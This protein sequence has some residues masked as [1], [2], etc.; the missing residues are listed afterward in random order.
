[1]ASG[2]GLVFGRVRVFELGR[3]LTPWKREFNEIAA[4]DPI[5]RLA[6]FQVESARKRIDVPISPEGQFV[7]ILPLGTYLLYHTPSVEPPFNEPIAAFQVTGE[8]GPVDLGELRLTVSVGRPL[9][10]DLA[11][12]TLSSVDNS[13]G[14]AETSRWFLQTHPG[15][16]SVRPDAF[17]VDAE[18]GG[19]F[20]NWSRDACARILARHGIQLAPPSARENRVGAP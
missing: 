9:S 7:W 19:L 3:E 11:T 4:E 5:I 14:N 12:Y 10:W 15:T 8:A 17:V 18:L 16:S 6:L 1:M 20:T 13:A 2:E